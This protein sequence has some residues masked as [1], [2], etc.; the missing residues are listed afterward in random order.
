MYATHTPNGMFDTIL[1]T[2]SL[3]PIDKQDGG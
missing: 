3:Q 2:S 1:D